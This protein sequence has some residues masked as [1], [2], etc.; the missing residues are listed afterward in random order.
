[1]EE[2]VDKAAA[3]LERLLRDPLADAV[4]GCVRVL[5]VS[6]PSGRGRYQEARVELAPEAP[7]VAPDPVTVTVVLPVKLWPH[8][9]M[10]LP[11]QIPPA[12]PEALEVD[13]EALRRR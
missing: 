1:M 11:A 5:S 9:G 13:W 7:G 8:E 2:W 12:Q 6:E 3:D 10:L 4:R